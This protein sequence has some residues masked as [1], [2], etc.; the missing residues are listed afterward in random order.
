MK[1][2]GCPRCGESL[3]HVECVPAWTRVRNVEIND[4]GELSVTWSGSMNYGDEGFDQMLE[5]SACLFEV[6][7]CKDGKW[8]ID[9]AVAE[10]EASPSED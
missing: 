3:Q 4:D 1:I 2:D 9:P 5:C 7:H 8:E 6:A 10:L